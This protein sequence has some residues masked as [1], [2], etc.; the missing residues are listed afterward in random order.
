MEQYK[1]MIGKINF[2]PKLKTFKTYAD[3][4]AESD[5]IRLAIPSAETVNEVDRKQIHDL[6]VNTL[7]L[8]ESPMD[9]IKRV[10]TLINIAIVGTNNQNIKMVNKVKILRAEIKKEMFN[11]CGATTG[12]YKED[13]AVFMVAKD[14]LILGPVLQG[15]E[16]QIKR[17][18]EWLG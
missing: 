6:V 8:A 3:L 18:Q 4:V 16:Y 2:K 10:E 7:S 5:L 1:N 17:I 15:I 11:I 13:Y 9:Y 12:Y 14:D